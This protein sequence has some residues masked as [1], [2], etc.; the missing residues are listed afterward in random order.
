VRANAARCPFCD[1]TIV[2]EPAE[3][4]PRGPISRAATMAFGAAV[5]TAGLL[6]CTGGKPAAD[7]SDPKAES[8]TSASAAATPT[9]A[10]T[11]TPTQ[12]ATAAPTPTLN[13]NPYPTAVPPYGAP[14][15]DGL[16]A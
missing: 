8:S 11:P 2:F 14:A 16:L 6:A 4:A 12:T 15:A 5:A 7:P 9:A 13:P 10:P 1:A 3:A